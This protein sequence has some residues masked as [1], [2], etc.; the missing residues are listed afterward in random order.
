[1]G[2]IVEPLRVQRL[3]DTYSALQ[4]QLTQATQQLSQTN[5][6]CQQ[7]QQEVSEFKIII[8]KT[9]VIQ[10]TANTDFS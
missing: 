4:E 10:P 1:M 7:L 5:S 8:I 9:D 2:L 3:Q 6:N